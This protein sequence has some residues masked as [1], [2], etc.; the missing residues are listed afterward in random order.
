MYISDTTSCDQPSNLE[1]LSLNNCNLADD[2]FLE[3]SNYTQGKLLALTEIDIAANQGLT[4]SCLELL[5][6]LTSGNDHKSM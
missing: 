5:M 6:K 3:L 2:F 1:V 4:P